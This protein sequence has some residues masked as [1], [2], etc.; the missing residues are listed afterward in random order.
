[1]DEVMAGFPD[2]PCVTQIREDSGWKLYLHLLY[3]SEV[4]L[5]GIEDRS[6]CLAL[7][8]QNDPLHEARELNHYAY[9][10][11][12]ADRDRFADRVAAMGFTAKSLYDRDDTEAPFGLEFSRVDVPA[13]WAITD[14]ITVPLFHAAR[15]C[16]GEY[17]GWG[18]PVIQSN[19]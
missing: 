17:D 3:P 12:S 5:L 18:S 6:V 10:A 14:E 4:E 9:F 1:V 15:E 13:M 8:Q 19:N 7:Q 16:R 2:H 11:S